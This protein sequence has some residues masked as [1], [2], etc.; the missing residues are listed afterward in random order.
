MKKAL[1]IALAALMLA[2][3]GQ[4]RSHRSYRSHSSSSGIVHVHGYWRHNHNGGMTYV[5]AYDRTRANG[6]ERDNW[7]TKGNRNPETGK[8]GTKRATH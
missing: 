8:W 5:H 4:A 7:S 3:P 2:V 1:L 6:T